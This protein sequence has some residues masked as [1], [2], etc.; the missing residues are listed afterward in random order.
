MEETAN[1][2][3]G[4]YH[5]GDNLNGP[6]NRPG[7]AAESPDN[8]LDH[9]N[10]LD[11]NQSGSPRSGSASSSEDEDA[12]SPHLDDDELDECARICDRNG[13]GHISFDEFAWFMMGERRFAPAPGGHGGQSGDLSSRGVNARAATIAPV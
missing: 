3:T 1:G 10:D 5:P 2:A 9:Q 12:L 7:A 11:D 13:D 8:L 6:Q 4:P